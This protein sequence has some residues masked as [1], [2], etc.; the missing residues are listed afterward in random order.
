[1][2]L[3]QDLLLFGIALAGLAMV[4]FFIKILLEGGCNA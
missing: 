3:L 2:F 4:L 1:M